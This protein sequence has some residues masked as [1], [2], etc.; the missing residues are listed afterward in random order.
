ML[1][2]V[3]SV[4]NAAAGH[5]NKFGPP[6]PW[7]LW[8]PLA[9]GPVLLLLVRWI[10]CERHDPNALPQADRI[11]AAAGVALDEGSATRSKRCRPPPPLPIPIARLRPHG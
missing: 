4:L 9:M 10:L 5:G 7:S 11:A 6:I 8:A 2:A 3:V 1:A